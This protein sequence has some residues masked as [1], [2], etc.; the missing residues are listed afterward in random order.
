MMDVPR[1]EEPDV[2]SLDG[3]AGAT[4]LKQP[5]QAIPLSAQD[6]QSE[7][8]EELRRALLEQLPPMDPSQVV[9]FGHLLDRT[10]KIRYEALRHLIQNR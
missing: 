4:T 3:H 5:S 6:V 9:P 2:P 10:V 8:P 1:K 7:D